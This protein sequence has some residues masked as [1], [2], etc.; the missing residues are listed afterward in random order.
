MSNLS[1]S[2]QIRNINN[3]LKAKVLKKKKDLAGSILIRLATDTPVDTSQALSNWR[4]GLVTPQAG[5]ILAHTKGSQ[6]STAL[7][8]TL[9]TQNIGLLII[10]RAKIKQ[11]IYIGNNLDYIPELNQ[12]KSPQAGAGFIEEAVEKAI[13]DNMKW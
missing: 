12:G 7:Q 3:N 1:F 5:T 11:A 4:V 6:G 9:T 13:K 2:Q 8:S 10:D